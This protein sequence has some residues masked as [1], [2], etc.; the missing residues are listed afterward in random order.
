VRSVRLVGDG[1]RQKEIAAVQYLTTNRQ[2]YAPEV[3]PKITRIM[4]WRW[5]STITGSRKNSLQS[6]KSRIRPSSC[7]RMERKRPS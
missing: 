4:H 1:L 5:R 3:Q 6:R 2:N 7:G